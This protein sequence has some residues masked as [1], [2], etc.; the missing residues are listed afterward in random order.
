[1][2]PLS[3]NSSNTYQLAPLI[4]LCLGYFMVILDITIVNVALPSIAKSLSG[5][6]AD[7]Q[8]I[9]DGYTLTFACLLLSAGNL[10]DRVGAKPVFLGGL[11]LFVI[12]S[13]GCGLASNFLLLI[14]F[15]LIQGMAAALLV[16]TSLALINSSYDCKAERAKAIGIWGGISGIAA[17]SGPIVGAALTAWLGWRAVFFVNVPIGIIGFLLTAKFVKY[18]REKSAKN[19]FDFSGQ[20]TSIIAIASLAFSLIEAG[21]FGWNARPIIAGYIIFIITFT[22]F[23]IIEYRS[24][25]PMFPLK[26][27]KSHI[28]STSIMIGM[29]I[30]TGFY[31]VLFILPLYFQQIREYSVF[32]TGLAILPLPGLIA[33]SSYLSGKM[34]SVMG[35]KS[36]TLLGLAI[37][38]TGFFSLLITGQHTPSYFLLILPLAA[39][40]FGTAFTMP[41]VT[42]AIMHAVP[43]QQTGMAAGALHTSRQIGSLIGVAIFGTLMSSSSHFMV[44]MHI[45]LI[46]GGIIFLA[47]CLTATTLKNNFYIQP[48]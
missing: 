27:F 13:L 20:F 14:F 46:I 31:G 21:R 7:L 12:T 40:G 45:N 25:A 17:A 41:A 19:T 30:N 47:G 2:Q 9:I 35:P 38:A 48:Q 29:F 8:W 3:H 4:A 36:P 5:N 32:M 39:I 42:I 28:F 44:G 6:M 43:S 33:V 37:G 34:A 1:M 26:F 18:T 16:P 22:V 24:K 11:A 23:I 15:R 10:A